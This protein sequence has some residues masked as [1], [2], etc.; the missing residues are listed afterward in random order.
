MRCN[1][2]VLLAC[3]EDYFPLSHRS[4]ICYYAVC[5]NPTRNQAAAFAI[6]V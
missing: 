5:I 4:E 1:D 3:N 2:L 6:K